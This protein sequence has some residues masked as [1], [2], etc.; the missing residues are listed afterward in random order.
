MN[1]GLNSGIQVTVMVMLP[2]R[3]PGHGVE[4][5]YD[6]PLLADYDKALKLPTVRDL[7]I[8]MF[9]EDDAVLYKVHSTTHYI[10]N[11]S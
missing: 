9:R 1:K 6:V 11:V 7:M 10:Y 4:S 5:M 8:R 2:F 3:Y